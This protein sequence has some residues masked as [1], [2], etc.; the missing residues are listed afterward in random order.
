M[1]LEE[2]TAYEYEESL[3]PILHDLRFTF[4]DQDKELKCLQDKSFIARSKQI[5]KKLV[6]HLKDLGYFYKNT[7]TSGYE[8]M[9]KDGEQCSA[10]IHLRF[11]SIKNTQSMRRE[12]KRYLAKT[13]D[14]DTHG[15]K[16]MMFK[17]IVERDIDKFWRYP[18]KQSLKAEMCGG[19]TNEQLEHM[20]QVAK[21]AY[22]TVV[23]V[24]QKKIDKK[25][26]T[27]TL[28]QRVLIQIKKNNDT[29]KIAIAKTF[30]ETY[31]KEDRP[32]NRSVIE[33]YVLNAMVKLQLTTIDEVL[34][35]WGY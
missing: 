13:Y 12:I 35:N 16:A 2:E 6:Q 4:S 11:Q 22:Q 7:Y 23:Q 14:E 32:L 34:H 31:I 17:G 27:D 21:D 10:H 33:G 24:N 30:I 1:D 26:N 18:L 25:D 5:W 29:T 28:F 19:F 3:A 20:H 8:T 15:N 9:N